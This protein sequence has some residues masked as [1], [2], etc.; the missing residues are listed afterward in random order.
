MA[1]TLD[2]LYNWILA[3][4]SNKPS[5]LSGSVAPTTDPYLPFAFYVHLDALGA[6]LHDIYT[7]D[8]NAWSKGLGGGG[9]DEVFAKTAEAYPDSPLAS[10]YGKKTI[11]QV[12]TEQVVKKHRKKWS[13]D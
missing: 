4:W 11:K 6:G 8:G 13:S 9:L 3:N 10:R 1:T 12:K 7:W 5:L 2:S